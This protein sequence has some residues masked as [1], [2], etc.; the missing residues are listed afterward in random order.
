MWRESRCSSR[1]NVKRPRVCRTADPSKHDHILRTHGPS[2]EGRCDLRH[3]AVAWP[4]EA[5]ISSLTAHAPLQLVQSYDVLA[6]TE[7]APAPLRLLLSRKSRPRAD[8]GAGTDGR[9][10]SGREI[11]EYRAPDP[12]SA[13]AP[14]SYPRGTS[15]IAET[16][17]KRWQTF[18]RKRLESCG[19]PPACAAVMSGLQ[20]RTA[21]ADDSTARTASPRAVRREGG[22]VR[23]ASRWRRAKP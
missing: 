12:N 16:V 7:L 23:P 13:R 22:G 18:S 2:V 10:P 4:G 9:R 6:R 17:G 8:V 11:G 19:G 3:R 14:L 5:V 21:A 15:A 1:A 20:S